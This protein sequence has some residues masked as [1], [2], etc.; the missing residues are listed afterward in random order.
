MYDCSLEFISVMWCVVICRYLNL[1][2]SFNSKSQA[3]NKCELAEVCNT[4]GRAQGN[5]N[6]LLSGM[7]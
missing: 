4:F 3:L 6:L 7:K 2:L 1:L 5:I